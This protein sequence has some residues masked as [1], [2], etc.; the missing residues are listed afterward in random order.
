MSALL[1]LPRLAGALALAVAT[2]SAISAC[3]ET[4]R[5]SY[6][7]DDA[8]TDASPSLPPGPALTDAEPPA[9]DAAAPDLADP[10]IVCKTTPCAVELVRGDDHFCARL[11]DG[12]V[13]CWGGDPYAVGVLGLST[14]TDA[15]AD[16]APFGARPVTVKGL[17]GVTQ[18]SAEV[19]T[20]CARDDGG[21]SCWGD[22]SSGQLGL[23]AAPPA[24]VDT[25][26]HPT[27]ARV[28][29][30]GRVEGVEVGPTAACARLTGGG[31][32][33]WGSDGA[34]KLLRGGATADDWLPPGPAVFPVGLGPIAWMTTGVDVGFAGTASGAVVSWGSFDGILGRVS[35]LPVDTQPDGVVGINGKV[36]S[37]PTEGYH[38]CGIVLT[39]AGRAPA[40]SELWCWGYNDAGQL[41][42]GVQDNRELPTRV[43]LIVKETSASLQHVSAGYRSTCVRMT[44]GSVYCAGTNLQGRLGIP[45]SSL[46]SAVFVAV[47]GVT[48]AASVAAG[49]STS[50]ALLLT[51]EVACWGS[52]ELGQLGLGTRD[53]LPHPKPSLVKLQ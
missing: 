53:E 19:N 37:F 32:S 44:S 13:R 49:R 51:G 6:P 52:N 17:A 16:A 42:I 15:G 23:S 8:G 2:A 31:Y 14:P 25:D 39:A 1:T 45:V 40:R 48:N 46:G 50:C 41:G 9:V 7:G 18:L 34:R 38:A 26:P 4:V 35:S 43:T 20:T 5:S 27:P 12:T 22:N 24:I 47:P 36:V 28:G 33:C 10:P 21:V 29:L 11:S 3:T 30:V